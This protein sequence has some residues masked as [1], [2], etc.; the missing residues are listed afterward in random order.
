MDSH[1][2][3]VDEGAGD[4]EE[5][6]PESDSSIVERLYLRACNCTHQPFIPISQAE[7][8]AVHRH[9]ATQKVAFVNSEGEYLY[10]ADEEIIEVQVI[11]AC[12]MRLMELGLLNTLIANI[13]HVVV[14]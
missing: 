5:D 14:T 9:L 11:P 13:P 10:D 2:S 6:R 3:G 7:Y 4:R 8:D 12:D 1:G